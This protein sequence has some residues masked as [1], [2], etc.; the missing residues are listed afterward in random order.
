MPD[1][2]EPHYAEIRNAGQ[3]Q[4]YEAIMADSKGAVTTG[5]LHAVRY[6]KD[7]RTAA[8]RI[9]QKNRRPRYRRCRRGT[10]R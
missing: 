4:I 10:G 7:N 2:F 6:L 8:A 5:L 1:R 9:R 3:V